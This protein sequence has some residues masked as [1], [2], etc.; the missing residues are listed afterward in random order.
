MIFEDFSGPG[1]LKKKIQDFPGDVGTL[2][3]TTVDKPDVYS[4]GA[5]LMAHLTESIKVLERNRN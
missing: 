5:L 4:L 2:F 1:I 3:V